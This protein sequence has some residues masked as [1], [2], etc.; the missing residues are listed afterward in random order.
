MQHATIPTE[1]Q[2]RIAELKRQLGHAQTA[3]EAALVRFHNLYDMAPIGYMVLAFDGTIRQA[4]LKAAALLGIER[5][6]LGAWNVRLERFV[7]SESRT[8]FADFVGAIT[9]PT[10]GQR[11][12]ACVVTLAGGDGGRREVQIDAL[13]L[14]GDHECHLWLSDLAS[15][16]PR[17]GRG[18][19][20]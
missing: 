19:D 13:G 11:R 8:V 15:R 12:G 3:R 4:N 5:A 16:P 9:R 6:Q 10:G 17:L 1:L 2:D 18:P 20:H 14:D 7:G